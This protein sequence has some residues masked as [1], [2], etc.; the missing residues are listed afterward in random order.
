MATTI[1]ATSKSARM[2]NIVTR[3]PIDSKSY[4]MSQGR[5][6]PPALAPTKNQPVILPVMVILRS[7]RESVVGK[8]AAIEKP[9]PNVPSQAAMSE[10]DQSNISPRLMIAPPKSA[11]KIN[12]GLKRVAIGMDN[13]RPAVRAPQKA[14]VR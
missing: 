13:S 2:I 12:R 6:I 3:G 7:A 5:N 1:T 9:A 14:E 8:M 4:P 10:F 11:S